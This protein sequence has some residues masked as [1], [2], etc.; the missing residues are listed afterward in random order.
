MASHPNKAV[1]RPP[2]LG[3]RLCPSC[4]AVSHP[5]GFTGGEE[6][7]CRYSPPKRA[8]Q[9]PLSQPGCA[10]CIQVIPFY[11]EDG[12]F[13][14]QKKCDF[15]SSANAVSATLSAGGSLA[16]IASGESFVGIPVAY[17]SVR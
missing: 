8:L 1:N 10:F 11:A 3:S 7:C 13:F 12:P 2:T 14:T 6:P 17:S 5:P 9:A 15:E 4:C 16:G